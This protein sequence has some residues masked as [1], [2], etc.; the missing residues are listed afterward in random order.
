[1]YND[2]AGGFRFRPKAANGE[3]IASSE[4]YTTKAAAKNGIESVKTNA[5]SDAVD[6]T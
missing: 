2:S 3:A 6:L 1:M 5:G 4:S